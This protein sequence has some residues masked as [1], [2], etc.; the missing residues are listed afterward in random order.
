MDK[1]Q[2]IYNMMAQSIEKKKHERQNLL[3]LNKDKF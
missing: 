2:D 1:H 3:D